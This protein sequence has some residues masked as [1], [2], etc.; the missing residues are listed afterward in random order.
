ME[1]CRVRK[2]A[3]SVPPEQDA[4]RVG[5]HPAHQHRTGRPLH[6][7]QREGDAEQGEAGSA[8]LPTFRVEAQQ[9]EVEGAH[10]RSR[11]RQFLARLAHFQ[12]DATTFGDDPRIGA[13]AALDH[14]GGHFAHGSVVVSRFGK[15][16][17]RQR[18]KRP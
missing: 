3:A 17:A 12:G 11:R 7:D 2:L 5:D 10:P 6:G 16:G 1:A 18:L 4:D 15:D 14:F 13:P 8:G 9:F